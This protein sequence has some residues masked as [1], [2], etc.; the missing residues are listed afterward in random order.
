[1]T[2][3]RPLPYQLGGVL[4][5]L[6]DKEQRELLTKVRFVFDQ[7][8]APDPGWGWPSLGKNAAGQELTLRDAFG[9]MKADIAALVKKLT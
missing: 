5:A 2:L 9:V 6:S 1:M 4:M 3:P 8:N 7:L